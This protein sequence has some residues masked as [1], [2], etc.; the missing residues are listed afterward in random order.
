MGKRKKSVKKSDESK[1]KSDPNQSLWGWGDDEDI[2][3]DNQVFIFVMFFGKYV[4][5]PTYF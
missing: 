5:L 3:L 4:L 2:A 1:P